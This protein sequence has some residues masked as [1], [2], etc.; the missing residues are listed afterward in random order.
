MLDWL[1][2]LYGGRSK[3]LL[4]R[5]AATPLLIGI[6]PLGGVDARCAEALTYTQRGLIPQIFFWIPR[7]YP[8]NIVTKI[9]KPVNPHEAIV[10]LKGI[11]GLTNVAFS[12][13]STRRDRILICASYCKETTESPKQP[14]SPPG[15]IA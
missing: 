1:A 14:P 13:V 15:A 3:E 8:K 12:V 6:K 9:I 2:Y 4:T 10:M 7:F 5:P 11:Y